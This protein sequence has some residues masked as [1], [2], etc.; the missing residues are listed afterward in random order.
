MVYVP[1]GVPDVD[2]V[3]LV[4]PQ[5]AWNKINPKN[6]ARTAAINK[7]RLR[8]SLPPTPRSARPLTGNQNAKNG[9]PCRW[10]PVVVVTRATVGISSTRL[11]GPLLRLVIEEPPVKEHG[12][13]ALGNA[14]QL[15]VML[16]G[17][18]PPMGVT[19][20]L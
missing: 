1:A 20:T 16:P 8:D 17:T 13:T 15:K 6:P 14:L 10:M 5:P 9:P 18:A 19:C 12:P 4:L 11:C 2:V 7:R 3:V